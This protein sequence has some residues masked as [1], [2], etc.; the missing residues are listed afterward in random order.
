MSQAIIL[1]E[2]ESNKTYITKRVFGCFRKLEEAEIIRD[3]KVSEGYTLHFF[4][5]NSETL[6]W[7]V[8]LYFSLCIS[9]K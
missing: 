4:G 3:K 7:E 6:Q 5:F 1:E 8:K 9:A 2:E